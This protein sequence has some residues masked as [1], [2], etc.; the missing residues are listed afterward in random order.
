MTQVAH[1]L[2]YT[3]F[4]AGD[5]EYLSRN[6]AELYDN[7]ERQSH[8]TKRR[9]AGSFCATSRIGD[10]AIGNSACSVGFRRRCAQVSFSLCFSSVLSPVSLP[11]PFLFLFCFRTNRFNTDILQEDDTSG[12][13]GQ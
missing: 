10:S 1:E 9:V 12:I 13:K 2:R 4:N 8:T 5:R 11:L 6:Y 3:G 7:H